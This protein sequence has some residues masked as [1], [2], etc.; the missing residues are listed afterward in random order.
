MNRD[1]IDRYLDETFVEQDGEQFKLS[2]FIFTPWR[3][4][5][6]GLEWLTKKHEPGECVV[7]GELTYT[8]FINQETRQNDFVHNY[9]EPEYLGCKEVWRYLQD[10]RYKQPRQY[11]LNHIERGDESAYYVYQDNVNDPDY[12][13]DERDNYTDYRSYI[14]SREWGIKSYALKQAVGFRCQKCGRGGDRKTLH[15]HHKHYKTLY[16]ERRKDLEV[17][18]VGCHKQYH[19]K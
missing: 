1:E 13:L 17:V 7:C 16:K 14:A 18:C 5:K 19:N 2:D 10:L 12:F 8:Q 11:Y 6:M 4:A 15:V 9:H 3:V